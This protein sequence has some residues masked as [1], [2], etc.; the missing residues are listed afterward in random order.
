M[1]QKTKEA[2]RQL[3]GDGMVCAGMKERNPNGY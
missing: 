1:T 3:K 2:G